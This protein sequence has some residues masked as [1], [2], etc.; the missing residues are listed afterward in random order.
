MADLDIS[1][2]KVGN[3]EGTITDF[4]VDP[5]TTDGA[6]DQKETRWQ[7]NKFPQQLGYYKSI[8]ELKSAIDAKARWVIGKGYKTNEITDMALSNF[9]G[10]GKDTFNSILMNQERVKEFSGDS[11]AH[12]IRL[13]EGL[14]KKITNFIGFTKED[15]GQLLNLKP[16]SPE[17]MV[18]IANKQGLIIRYE[19][20]SRTGSKGFKK[21]TPDQIFH[22]TRDRVADEI[23]G[24]GVIEA[25]EENIL[26]RNEAME[27]Y[28]KLLHRNVYPIKWLEVDTDDEAQ[29]ASYQAKVDKAFTQGE[30]IVVPKGTTMPPVIVGTAPNSTLNPLPWINALTQKFYQEI[31]VPQI[32]VGGAQEI[33]EASAKIAYLAW[34]QTVEEEQLYIEEQVLA[35]LNLEIDL[36]FPASLQNEMLS[37]NRKAETMQA[38]TPEDTALTGEQMQQ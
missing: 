18:I 10:H 19:Q 36:E 30:N 7:N 37:D 27:D 29:V 4:S 1:S 38:A 5:Q 3:F 15:I 6:Q 13:K 9:R 24:T 32:I 22:L 8:P 12:I 23:H 17:T 31:G 2:A 26:M 25:C 34:E 14:F 28:R 20:T 16:L 33:T 21:F 35:Q 11:Y